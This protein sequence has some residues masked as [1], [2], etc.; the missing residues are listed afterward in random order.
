MNLSILGTKFANLWVIPIV[1][2]NICPVLNLVDQDKNIRDGG[3]Y[4]VM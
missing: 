1:P 2:C 4:R 3:P